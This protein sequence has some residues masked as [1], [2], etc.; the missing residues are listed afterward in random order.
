MFGT[1]KIGQT[2]VGMKASAFSPYI[3][4]QIF[5]EDF[6]LK[7]QDGAPEPDLFQKMG[8]VM[9]KEAE[10][11]SMQELMKLNIEGYYEWLMQF[12][13]MDVIAATGEISAIYLGQAAK[14]S[15]PKDEGD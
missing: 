9:A 4:K 1:V 5:R 13:P 8:Y 10:T 7:L 14:S 6:L 3:F 2:D 15:A 12:E 11:S